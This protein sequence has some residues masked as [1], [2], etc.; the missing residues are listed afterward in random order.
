MKFTPD[1]LSTLSMA[2]ERKH[3][4][5]ATET[6]RKHKNRMKNRKHKRKC[7]PGKDLRLSAYFMASH[8]SFRFHTIKLSS[9]IAHTHTPETENIPKE[10]IRKK[11]FEKGRNIGRLPVMQKVTSA[12]RLS[13]DRSKGH[14]RGNFGKPGKVRAAEVQDSVQV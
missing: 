12:V 3:R 5:L 6:E 11:I 13:I 2:Q 9:K 4:E 8:H 7:K 14:H 1:I 10:K